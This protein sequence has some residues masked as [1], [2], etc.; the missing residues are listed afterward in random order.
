MPN[1]EQPRKITDI[2]VMKAMS[3]PVRMSLI[4]A[5]MLY[6]PQTATEVG[7]KI[8]ETATTCSFHL[9]QLAKYGFIEETPGGKGRSR[10]WRLANVSVSVDFDELSPGAALQA[11]QLMLMARSRSLG[12]LDTWRQAQH[13][14][15]R[16]WRSAATESQYV[17]FVT[18]G[19]L[20]EV[21]Q[22]VH[23]ILY[24]YQSRLTDASERPEGSLPV[25]ALFY[26]F[27]VAE[28]G[29]GDKGVER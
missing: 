26:A 7:E 15:S 27:P 11:T 24:K 9:R 20:K 19:E 29:N 28:E 21:T 14:F 22:A 25:E 8:G 5:L 12:R 3:H 17:L 18:A 1:V 10:P 13:S 23:E 2:Q 6:G 16:E 4:E